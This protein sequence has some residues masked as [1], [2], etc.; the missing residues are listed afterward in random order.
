MDDGESLGKSNFEFIK[1]VKR[2]FFKLLFSTQ[3]YNNF[4]ETFSSNIRKINNH[5]LLYRVSSCIFFDYVF[6]G[7]IETEDFMSWFIY[8][9]WQEGNVRQ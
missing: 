2:G 7:T 1:D 8:N 6:A 3:L 4:L 9:R 5:G